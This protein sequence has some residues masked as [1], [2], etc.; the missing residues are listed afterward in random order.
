MFEQYNTIPT[1]RQ[2]QHIIY[3]KNSSQTNNTFIHPPLIIPQTTSRSY[4]THNKI[5]KASSATK[6]SCQI[7]RMGSLRGRLQP[8]SLHV[9][10][11]LNECLSRFQSPYT[12]NKQH[13]PHK[14]R[15]SIEGCLGMPRSPRITF[16]PLCSGLRVS[17]YLLSLYSY[18]VVGLLKWPASKSIHIALMAGSDRDGVMGKVAL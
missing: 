12:E 10:G 14:S 8:F 4:H 2:N 11:L 13:P 16:H 15:A 9:N 5:P 17:S 18:P 6:V 7:E 3:T 1:Y